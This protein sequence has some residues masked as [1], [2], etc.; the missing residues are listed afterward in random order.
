MSFL[1]F[2]QY[3]IRKKKTINVEIRSHHTG[4]L[5]G[6]IE[7]DCAWRKYVFVTSCS[8]LKFDS[9]CQ[10]EIADYLDKLMEKRTSF[11]TVEVK[12]DE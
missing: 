6:E 11:K 4:E 3:Q 7:W 1:E 8:G 5:L 10:R 9:G 12:S 2:E